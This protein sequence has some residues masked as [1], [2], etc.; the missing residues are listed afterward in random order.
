MKTSITR[1]PSYGTSKTGTGTKDAPRCF[2]LKLK[3]ATHDGFGA[4]STTHDPQLIVKHTDQ[5][6]LELLGTVHVDDIKIAYPNDNVFD[7]LIASLEKV[8][9]KG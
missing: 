9:G 7:R 5:S 3:Q 6:E 4:K 2:G 8:F 1:K